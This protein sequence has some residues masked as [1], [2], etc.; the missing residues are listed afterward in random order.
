MF[1]EKNKKKYTYEK[2]Q[3]TTERKDNEK[4]VDADNG[5]P[6]NGLEKSQGFFQSKIFFLGAKSLIS[7]KQ[8]F[9]LIVGQLK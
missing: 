6:P 4:R 5:L 8:P 1:D 2:N 7:F 9:S 3:R